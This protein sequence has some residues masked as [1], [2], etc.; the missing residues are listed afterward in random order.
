M[1][2]SAGVFEGGGVSREVMSWRSRSIFSS[3]I[4]PQLSAGA[5]RVT[6]ALD[7]RKSA[8]QKGLTTMWVYTAPGGG[9]AWFPRVRGR[10]WAFVALVASSRDLRIAR[11]AR[12][13]Q[14]CAA[15]A[16]CAAAP[17]VAS[18]MFLR[19]DCVRE[20]RKRHGGAQG[21]PTQPTIHGG[22]TWRSI[23]AP[24][25]PAPIFQRYQRHW[26]PDP[27]CPR[28]GQHGDTL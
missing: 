23:L 4:A 5:V 28:A 14:Q 1:S 10:S 17:H 16:R 27:C 19:L 8:G 6:G 11:I 20:A 15:T 2:V 13:R 9:T 26:T 25:P 12:S 3:S 22:P 21:V 24:K 18:A 7:E